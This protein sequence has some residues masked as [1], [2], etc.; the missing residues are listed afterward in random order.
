MTNWM[1]GCEETK[2]RGVYKTK[3]GYRIRV[4]AVDPRTGKLKEVNRTL[5]GVTLEEAVVKRAEEKTKIRKGRSREARAR[6][7]YADYC[8]SLLKRKI[9]KGK[10]RTKKGRRTWVDIQDLHLIPV[11]GSWFIDQI[12]KADVEEWLVEQGKKVARGEKRPVVAG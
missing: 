10:F 11:F 1:K 2:Y 5:K 12:Q 6:T 7:R 3:K 9:A 4:R 8:E